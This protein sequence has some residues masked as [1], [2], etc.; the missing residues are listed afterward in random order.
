MPIRRGKEREN[1]DIPSRFELV[2][3]IVPRRTKIILRIVFWNPP[4]NPD[5]AHCRIKIKKKKKV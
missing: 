3:M 4:I 1:K 5:K 2:I